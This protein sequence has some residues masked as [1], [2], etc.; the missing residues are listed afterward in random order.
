MSEPRA[1]LEYFFR[2]E[3]GWLGAV[4][5]RSLG[6]RRLAL[7]EDVVQAELVVNRLPRLRLQLFVPG[8]DRL[9]SISTIRSSP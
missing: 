7:V 2:H 5:T 3:F 9:V 8:Y 4:L 1:L 6:V